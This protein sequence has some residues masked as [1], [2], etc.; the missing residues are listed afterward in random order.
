VASSSFIR[1]GSPE[2]D[3]VKKDI[4]AD[5]VEGNPE[6][7]SWL[8]SDDVQ[9]GSRFGVWESSAGKFKAKM[10]GIT[11]FCHILEGEAHI[12]NL[13]DGQTHTVKAGDSFVMEEGFTCEW[14]VPNH[15][16]KCFAISNLVK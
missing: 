13:S 6:H 5:I 8:Y 1:F 16:K 14:H 9:T 2:V 7:G 10:D 11:E 4:S 12:T 3:R 15:I